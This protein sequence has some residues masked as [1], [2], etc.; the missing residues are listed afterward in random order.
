MQDS[1]K[2]TPILPVIVELPVT[3]GIFS[4][5]G[6][7]PIKFPNR[8]NIKNVA[9]NGVQDL[10]FSCQLKIELLEIKIIFDF[11][12]A[13]IKTLLELIFF[14]KTNKFFLGT[15]LSTTIKHFLIFILLFLKILLDVFK[16]LYP[17]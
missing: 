15:F 9:I 8:I 11:F 7:I 6:I 10:Y 14:F 4:K 1:A 3:P 17:I 13:T 16:I 2:V 12:S 5:N